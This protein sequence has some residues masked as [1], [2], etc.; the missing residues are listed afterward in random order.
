MSDVGACTP[1]SVSSIN[2]PALG[3]AAGRIPRVALL[4]SFTPDGPW[5]FPRDPLMGKLRPRFMMRKRVGLGP[6]SKQDSMV[7]Q[8]EKQIPQPTKMCPLP[9]RPQGPAPPYGGDGEAGAGA[10]QRRTSV[11]KP[12]T[13]G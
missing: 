7:L 4:I 2:P 13:S 11:G 1:F 9:R 5:G 8:N 12:G 10:S 3:L 6:L